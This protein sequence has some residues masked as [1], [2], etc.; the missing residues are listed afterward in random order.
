MSVEQERQKWDRY[1]A[2]L[3]EGDRETDDVRSLGAELAA[4]LAPLLADGAR[5]LEAGCGTGHQSLA[6]ARAGRYDLTLLDFSETAIALARDNFQREGFEAEFLVDDAFTHGTAEFD[7][8]FNVGVF[9]HYDHAAQTQM[10]RA[11]A[12]RSK[13]YVLMVVPNRSCYWYWIHR[14]DATARSAWPFGKEI[15][16]RGS[17]ETVRDAGLV[18]IGRVFLGRAWTESFLMH[19]EGIEERL[20]AEIIEVH[21]SPLLAVEHTSYLVAVL[22]GVGPAPAPP[23][24]ETCEGGAAEHQMETMTAALADALALQ[25]GA[26]ERLR[27]ETLAGARL[28]GQLADERVAVEALE[29][30]TSSNRAITKTRDESIAW[31]KNELEVRDERIRLLEVETSRYQTIAEARDESIAWL[32]DELSA[33]DEM[34]GLLTAKIEDRERSLGAWTERVESLGATVA[35]LTQALEAEQESAAKL[36]GEAKDYYQEIVALQVIVA[37]QQ[38]TI[39]TLSREIDSRLEELSKAGGD[40]ERAERSLL[41]AISTIETALTH[42]S[43]MLGE[44]VERDE[45]LEEMSTLREQSR[46]LQAIVAEREATIRSGEE[47]IDWLRAEVAHRERRLAAVQSQL[48]QSESRLIRFESSLGGR[49]L[50]SYGKVKYRY[51]LPLYQLAGLAPRPENSLLDS[52]AQPSPDALSPASVHPAPASLSAVP[53]QRVPAAPAG[54]SPRRRIA[55]ESF[56]DFVTLLPAMNPTEESRILEHPFPEGA[57][58]K[59]DV[60]CFSIIDWEFR[61]QRPQQIM[62]QFA[63][64]GHRVFYLSVSRFVAAGSE[65]IRVTQIRDNV[66]EVSVAVERNPDIYGEVI[67]AD[68]NLDA[69]L[70]ALDKLRRRYGIVDAIGYVMIASWE[71]IASEAARRWGWRI[72]YDCMDEWENFPGIN[73]SILE[74]ERRLVGSCD[75]LVVTAQL[76]LEK[77]SA[78]SRPTVLARN[79]VDV[80]FYEKRYGPN[81]LLADAKHPVVGYYGAIADWFDLELM[82]HVAKRRP[83][84][85]FVLLG[86]VFD[87]DVSQ[88]SAL[89]NVQLLGQQPYDTMPQYLYHFDA[90]LIPF[91]VNPITEATDPVKLYEYLCAGKPVVS[92][93]LSEVR[94]Y[95]E[96][97]Y[98]AETREEFLEKLDLAVREDDPELGER[99][100]EFAR[101]HTWEKRFD[102]VWAGVAEVTPKA[103]I[104]VVTYNNLAL[105][106]LCL[107]SI[108]RNTEYP[109]YEVIVVDNASADGTPAYLKHVASRFP[110][111]SVILNAENLGFAKANNQGIGRA[112]GEYIVLLN[113]DT[114]VPPGWLT[115]LLRYLDDPQVGLVGPVTN[116]VGNEAKIDVPYTRYTEFE[117]FAR[118]YTTAHE[119]LV[120]DIHMLAMFCIAMRRETYVKVGQLDEQFGLGM[121]EDD[122]YSH[123]VRESGLRVICAADIFIHHVGQASFKKLIRS[124]TYDELFDRNKGLFEAKW[125]IQWKPHTNRSLRFEPHFAATRQ[126]EASG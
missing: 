9:E 41:N 66:F 25:I 40:R 116:F 18:P 58:H 56:Y 4:T 96:Y 6:L 72:A 46:F 3:G 11:M 109:N 32:K 82:T 119:G 17:V 118:D 114:I 10:L 121:F 27:Q 123:R 62:S 64:H 73:E 101:A 21:R 53:V 125:G 80:G 106:R 29:V 105:N 97:V 20:R 31:L 13:R 36:G 16:S 57:Y 26:A 102:A 117:T 74:A 22:A 124:G 95:A 34:I 7:L 47:G 83:D 14:I 1:Y 30:E 68:G 45:L 24:W 70:G 111:V 81:A 33:R 89:P 2:T 85:T 104:V 19:L 37:N 69:I 78:R 52:H 87:V 107:E 48:I 108:A 50:A 100:V 120:A 77:W 90:C 15:P 122:D 91:K 28:V 93:A 67:G 126:P 65:P 79:G 113:N 86:G 5:I 98:L 59:A 44:V 99:R 49:L 88:L 94:P 42:Q 23:G 112:L 84:Y 110:N 8:V 54:V 63:A 103:S 71:R 76:L 92:V 55:G 75:L 61:F 51:L 39:T 12:S 38:A 115:R 43:E 60:V 35:S